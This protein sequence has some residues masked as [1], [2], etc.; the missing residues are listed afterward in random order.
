MNTGFIFARYRIAIDGSYKNDKQQVPLSQTQIGDFNLKVGNLFDEILRRKT[1]RIILQGI[2]ETGWAIVVRPYTLS[3]CCNIF[4]SET[5]V[6]EADHH[7]LTLMPLSCPPTM[8]FS[9]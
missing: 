9:P 1:G 5:V 7:D 8:A 3:A 4:A 6:L 2:W